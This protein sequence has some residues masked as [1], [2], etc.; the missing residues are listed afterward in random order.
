MIWVGIDK[1]GG[2]KLTSIANEIATKLTM[3]GFK[4]DKKFKPHLTIFR[5]KKKISDIS[6]IMKEYEAL[7]FGTEII[8]KIKLKKSVLSPKGPE[9]SDLL[10]V[11]EK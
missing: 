11:N 6:S 1:N 3:L 7:E 4:K 9:Y 5:M 8:S 2:E 10:V